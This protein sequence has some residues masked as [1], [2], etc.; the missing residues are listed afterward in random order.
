MKQLKRL[1]KGIGIFAA[2]AFLI[3]CP[4]LSQGQVKTVSG[5]VTD[6][7]TARPVVGA[8]IAVKGTLNGIASNEKGEFSI[9]ASDKDILLITAVGYADLE[10]NANA[11]LTNV[12][13]SATS[14]DMDNVIVVGY[15]K[16]KKATL[17]G[18]VE[19]VDAKTFESRAVT[20]V[21]LALQGQTPGLVVTRSSPRPGNEGLAFRIRG[22]T[23]VNGSNPLIVVDGVPTLNYYSFQNMNP[24]DI[25]SISVLKDGAA[26]IYGSRASNGVILVTTKRGKGKIKVDYT[27][28]L[29]FN[30]NGI[31]GYS[32]SMQEYATM[33]LE[34]NKEEAAPNWWV[35]GTKENL[36]KMQSGYEGA[37]SFATWP[38]IDYYIF[39]A[40]RLEEMFA[41]RYSYQHNLSI[42][43]SNEKSGYRLSFGL[44]DNQGNLATAYDG[45][46]QYN[47]RFNH[48][49]KFTEK[50]K[51]ET[52]VSLINAKTSEPSVGLD[53]TLYGAD[54][55]FFPA[56]NPYGQWF[57][58]FNGVDGGATRNA[59][60]MTADGGRNDK[61]SL[62]GRIDV[63][64]SY[65]LTSDL[66]LEGRASLQN[67]RFN[68]E[69]YV[70]KVPLY[71][72]YGVQTAIGNG[73][74][75]TNNRYETY[76]WQGLYQYYEALLNYNKQIK[77]V[78][79]LS[80]T[81][82]INAEKNSSQ[83]IRANRVG[84]DDQGV[85]DI[86][87]ASTTTQTNNGSKS[88]NGRYSYLA[89]VN[90]NYAEKYLL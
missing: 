14:G 1:Q 90:Y 60:A 45:Q 31:T 2:L 17:T 66:S 12:R 71:N 83:W 85:Y 55:P 74:D 72:W 21:G 47:V 57:A 69:F 67:E 32:P 9:P 42:A 11:D 86:S 13:L 40:N 52:S 7:G 80:A 10:I 54:M 24:D 53:N 81:A 41:T 49:Y 77:G 75:G 8:S 6:A 33:W 20:N 28:N 61:N 35:W 23:S 30:T 16:Q 25:E 26:A 48:D 88:L 38:N 89:R 34:A 51:L 70:L 37:Y 5:I 18:A 50:L 84:F 3:I 4:L 46:K 27:A 62:T 65:K 58:T 59:A 64:A 29:R 43:G 44:A 15:G 36:L 63:K 22:A 76:A 68:Q 82:G 39:N 19:V 87:L 78:H 79:N 56:K 73:T